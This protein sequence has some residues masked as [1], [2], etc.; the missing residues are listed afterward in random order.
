MRVLKK[1]IITVLILCMVMGLTACDKN[2]AKS[3]DIEEPVTINVWYQDDKFTDYI[4]YVAKT[5]SKDNSLVTINYQLVTEDNY[6]ERL[7]EESVHGNNAPDIFFMNTDNLEK[8]SLMGLISEN[9]S[10]SQYYTEKNYSNTA[11]TAA[12]YKGKLYGY[13]ISFNVAFL[14]Y[15]ADVASEVSNFKEL[16]DYCNNYIVDD[17]NQ[18]ITNLVL[19][20]PS[21]MFINYAFSCNS[22]NLGGT[23]GDDSSQLSVNKELLSKG[24]ENFLKQKDIFGIERNAY[25]IEE[26]MKQF[27]DGKVAYTITDANHLKTVTDS[28]INYGICDIPDFDGGLNTVSISENICA[29]V[30]PYAGQLKTAKAVAHA[31]SYDY[32]DSLYDLSG[33]VSSKIV[34]S[35]DAS[36]ATRMGKLYDIYASS[37]VKAK[38]MG[39][40]YFYT[41]YDIMIHQ[42][43]DGE[44]FKTTIDSFVNE[45][46]NKKNN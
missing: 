15:N 13:P 22:I 8:A 28:S 40:A 23:S 42:V 43:W 39:S 5:F 21:D 35:K 46:Q 29:F 33:A 6:V 30:N 4:D 11:L 32:S 9:S 17:K 20:N 25:T 10:Y 7:Y 14:L 44:D 12:S 38:F 36:Y 41:K 16:E 27:A 2:A 1:T 3:L 34:K 19:W 18:D 24:M 45:I 26:I 37:D 31:L